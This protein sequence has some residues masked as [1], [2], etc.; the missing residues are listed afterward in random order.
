MRRF[1]AV[2]GSM[3]F[4]GLLL[5]PV[6]TFAQLPADT[7]LTSTGTAANLVGGD[8]GSLSIA[9]FIGLYFIRPVLGLVGLASFILTFYAGVLWMTAAGD[10]KQIGKAKDILR[11][12]VI[13]VAILV[14]AYTVST[15]L[16]TALTTGS[17]V[18]SA[19]VAPGP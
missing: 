2:F 19:P 6:L 15:A 5:L 7:G 14:S 4:F 12:V 17:V 11:A 13:G 3:L 18:G 8:R 9:A 10:D 1:P 16:I